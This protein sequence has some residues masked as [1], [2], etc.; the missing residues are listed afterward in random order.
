[1]TA[2]PSSGTYNFDPAASDLVIEAF[3]RC[4]VRASALTAQH[5]WDARMSC[6]LLL[7]QWSV[8]VPN[9]WL[10][11]LL[12]IALTQGVTSYNIPTNTVTVLDAYI[13][14]FQ[15]G[16]AVNAPL[17]YSTTIGSASVTIGWPGNNLYVNEW[18]NLVVPVSVGG[19]I[20][21]GF[22]QVSSVIDF[23]TVTITAASPATASVSHGGVVPQ[24][25]V[26]TGS[27]TVY[28]SLP[29]HGL[30]VGQNFT[31]NLPTVVGGLALSGV[32]QVQSVLS[33]TV[34]AFTAAGL[35]GSNAVI[36]ENAGQQSY[37]TQ[38]ANTAPIDRPLTPISRTDYADQPNKFAQGYPSTYWFNRQINPLIYLWQPPDQNGPYVLNLYVVTQPQDAVLQAGATL[39][40]PYRF[41]E[42]F[43]AGLARRLARKYAPQLVAELAVEEKMAWDESAQEDTEDCAW[44]ITP[45]LGGYFS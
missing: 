1:M 20:L 36:Y 27:S 45:G 7:S 43:A 12:Q 33:T 10:V 9:L 21:Q 4:G 11:T 42:P 38:L 13:R 32:Y 16:N 35:A 5:M 31:V 41:L 25:T 8:R 18:I 39:N 3:S 14:Q 17:D 19:I 29:N 30:V 6:Q 34:F 28:V 15:V 40:I 37:Q 2:Q 23:N 44:H 22:Y 26:N 24:F